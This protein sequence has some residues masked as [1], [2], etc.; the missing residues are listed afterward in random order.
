MEF[1]VAVAF[2]VEASEFLFAALA[3]A[4]CFLFIDVAQ[5]STLPAETLVITFE[6]NVFAELAFDRAVEDGNL[7]RRGEADFRDVFVF[8]G[9]NPGVVAFEHVFQF[10]ADEG[11][12]ALHVVGADALA[13]GW[14]GDENTP[15]GSFGPCRERFG[16]QVDHAPHACAADVAVGY[17]HGLGRDIGAVD[18]I[19]ELA[20]GRVVVVEAVEQRGVEI[21]P[22]LEGE[23][24]AV[25]ARID[26]GGNQ[27]GLNQECARPAHR[28]DQRAVAAP[29]AAQDYPRGEHLVDG[30]LGLR[31]AVAALVERLA[32]RIERER[33]VAAGD[34]HVDHHVGALQP[35]ARTLILAVTVL[36]PVDDGVFHAVGHEARVGEVVAVGN[37]VDRESASH[38]HQRPPVELLGAVVKL[39]G[40]AGRKVVE[41][42]E[43]TQRRAA[44]QVGLVEH[45]KIALELHHA[46]PGFDIQRAECAQLLGQHLLQSLEG[47]GYHFKLFFHRS[48]C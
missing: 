38:R 29:A 6:D 7:L 18:F 20:L 33:H 15:L 45:F 1:S 39:V 4:L 23:V 8:S 10:L 46:A 25:N 5:A 30:R 42:F 11:V 21:F 48:G 9:D 28:V 14:I 24:F 40:V 16:L 13:V 47:F 44:A 2:A 41:G 34:V 19:F 3:A 35:H 17:L 12:E 31:H 26:V 27:S 37:R 36:E 43:N 22:V 32:R